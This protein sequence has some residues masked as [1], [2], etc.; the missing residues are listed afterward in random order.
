MKNTLLAVEGDSKTIGKVSNDINKQ[1]DFLLC[2]SCFWCASYFNFGE[3]TI[4]S[5]PICHN[6]HID[7]LPVSF[8]N[9]T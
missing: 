4:I 2:P 5:C 1:I 6:N 9:K 8:N 3:M 7:Q